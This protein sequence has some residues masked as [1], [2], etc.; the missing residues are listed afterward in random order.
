MKTAAQSP[1]FRSP[2]IRAFQW[3]LARQVERLD[4]LTAQ[5]PRLA[6]WGYQEIVLHLEDALEYPSLPGVARKDAYSQRELGVFTRAAAQAGLGVVPI[7]NL[8]GHTQYLLKVPELRDLNECRAP[9][10]S[11][12]LHGQICPLHP[13]THEIVDKLLRD[14]AD[15]CT[16][17]VVHAG[18]D[19]SYFLGRHPLSRVE[20]A[21]SGLAAHFAR[22]VHRLNGQAKERGLRLGLW[23]DMLALL[24]ETIDLLPFGVIAYDWYYHPF[25]DRPR[26]EVRNFAEYD[27]TPKLSG[28]KIDYW[29]C[30]MAGSFRHE[31][32]PV[33]RERLGNIISWWERCIR[34]RAAGFLLTSWESQ[35]LAAELPMAMAAA[36]AGLWIENEK[37]PRRLWELGCR[38]AF[39]KQGNG[40]AARLWSS[41]EK[42]FIGYPR[43]QINDRWDA[44]V[45][46]E[47]IESWRRE[48]DFCTRLSLS[49]K[50]LPA[51]SASLRFRAYLAK[52]DYFVR[53]AGK[54]VFGLRR[55]RSQNNSARV[56]RVLAGLQREAADFSKIL[57]GARAAARTMWRRTRDPAETGPNE[58]ILEADRRRLNEWRAWL[59]RCLTR[60]DSVW[61]PSPVAGDWQM[62]FTIA[63]DA[64]AQ[65]KVVVEQMDLD[66]K[67]EEIYSVFLIEFRARAARARA[68]LKYRLSAPIAWAS[69]PSPPLRL[70]ICARGFGRFKLMDTILT[71]GAKKIA[72]QAGRRGTVTL[73][74][75]APRKGFPDFDWA[76]NRGVWEPVWVAGPRRGTNRQ[77]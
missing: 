39:G 75:P 70:R 4:W 25:G 40:S 9:D 36:A 47:P 62:M 46:G 14:V 55:A 19:E 65:Q 1:E 11:P 26:I 68:R 20:I 29:G 64:P 63:V 37:D 71:N 53:R 69:P 35:R 8:L 57:P 3:D 33:F 58:L 45:T 50:L 24:P 44:A 34:T 32:L 15:F 54:G 28:R 13:R 60:P 48:A 59:R 66:G 22:Y 12:L 52:R 10:G 7:V 18:L 49:E 67:W 5:L 42:P 73:G 61:D 56:R 6:D 38:R 74:T 51:V 23:A 43:W 30:P 77:L 16:A 17:G 76:K 72:V 41:D 2:P 31:V 27:L 21:K